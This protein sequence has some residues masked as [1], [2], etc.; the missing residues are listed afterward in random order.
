ML[1]LYAYTGD[2]VE[3]AGYTS[4]TIKKITGLSLD[5]STATCIGEGTSTRYR[6]GTSTSNE[7]LEKTVSV[8]GTDVDLFFVL[9]NTN[10]LL[11]NT[12]AMSLMWDTI[13]TGIDAPTKDVSID[14][15]TDIPMALKRANTVVNLG[16]L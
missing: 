4:G 7:I 10:R 13:S 12:E 3:I 11:Y 5:A 2:T 1:A 8:S 15:P 14:I 6:V 9:R 16:R